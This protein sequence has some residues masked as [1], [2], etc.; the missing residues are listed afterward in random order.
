MLYGIYNAPD[1]EFILNLL[2]PQQKV[3]SAGEANASAGIPF[4][5]VIMNLPQSATEFLDVFVGLA[6]D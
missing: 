3:S 5:E 1:R 2:K 4:D 6:T